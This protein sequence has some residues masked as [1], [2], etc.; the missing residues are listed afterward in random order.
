MRF[1]VLILSVLIL[2]SEVKALAVASD[3]LPDKTLELME[4]T[5]T[6]YSIELQNPESFDV[7]VKVTYE[8]TFMTPL[9]LKEEYTLEPQTQTR[10]K[11][12]ITAPKYKKNN[13]LFDIGFTVHQLTGAG[14]GVGFLP[15]INKQF[16]LKVIKDPN[17]FYIDDY[18]KYILPAAV[19]LLVI[20]FLLRNEFSSKKFRN[21]KVFR[22]RKLIK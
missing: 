6:F 10:I 2:I 4:G 11:F 15:K 5:S 9:N 16:S 1:V 12:N 17:R 7:N 3:Y 14:G 21:N 8:D 19:V 13:N 20:Y 22:N 18:Y